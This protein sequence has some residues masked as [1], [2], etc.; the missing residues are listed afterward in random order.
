MPP[1]L[2]LTDDPWREAQRHATITYL[3]LSE[4]AATVIVALKKEKGDRQ[5]WHLKELDNLN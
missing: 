5:Q 4:A 3:S 1:P 2:P